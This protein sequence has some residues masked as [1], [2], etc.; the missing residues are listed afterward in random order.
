MTLNKFHILLYEQKFSNGQKLKQSLLFLFVIFW[1]TVKILQE[2]FTMPSWF[3]QLFLGG[4]NLRIEANHYWQITKQ[5]RLFVY[6]KFSFIS[7]P[8]QVCLIKRK[9]WYIGAVFSF[10]NAQVSQAWI[11]LDSYGSCWIRWRLLNSILIILRSFS[12][13]I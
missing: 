9:N 6:I 10:S 3:N 8:F 4:V 12:S 7:R 2:I 1:M 5:F 11:S 13:L